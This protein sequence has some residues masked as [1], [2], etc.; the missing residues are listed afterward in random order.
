VLETRAADPV[1]P[2]AAPRLS[3]WARAAH[4]VLA[5]FPV[6]LVPLAG[7]NGLIW[8]GL[9]GPVALILVLAAPLVP[10]AWVLT[11]LLSV[12]R[13]AGISGS[14]RRPQSVAEWLEPIIWLLLVALTWWLLWR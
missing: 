7:E 5:L 12:Y 9:L 2:R 10:V 14:I 11:A 1:P 13:L 3:G 4:A 6:G 8:L